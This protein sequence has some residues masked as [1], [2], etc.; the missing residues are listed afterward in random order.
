MNRMIVWFSVVL[1]SLTALFG[2]SA[3]PIGGTTHYSG[4]G[5]EYTS[6]QQVNA[7]AVA[8]VQVTAT[9]TR[10]TNPGHAPSVTTDVRVDRVI[11]GVVSGS[12][13]KIRQFGSL[14]PRVVIEDADPLL[15]SGQ[16]YVLFLDRF[17]YG[18][19]RDTGEYVPNEE[20]LNRGG[21]LHSLGPMSP[22]LP[23]SMPLADLVRAVS[24]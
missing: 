18:P 5:I 21:I 19:G 3:G 6:I 24:R 1:F 14:D 13:I 16:S 4:T 23:K 17:T 2:C 11:R 15:Q 12:V 22:R 20:L 7:E 10:K 9:S 8:V